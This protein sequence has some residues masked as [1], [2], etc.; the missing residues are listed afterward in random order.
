MQARLER[1][2]ALFATVKW[3]VVAA[4]LFVYELIMQSPPPLKAIAPDAKKEIIGIRPGEKINEILLTEEE[5]CHAREFEDYFV[6]EPEYPF[7]DSS[8]LSGGKKLPD[9]FRYTSDNNQHWL[10]G[11]EL[12]KMTKEL[13][14]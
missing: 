3:W 7:W 12:R 1:G 6:I 5:A 8:L 11:E 10:T 4:S 9:G 2:S 14:G 13:D